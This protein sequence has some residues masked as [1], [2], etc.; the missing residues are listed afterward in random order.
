MTMRLPSLLCALVLLATGLTACAFADTEALDARACRL[1]ADCTE[2]GFACEAGYCQLRDEVC[3]T[4]VD[5]EDGSYCNGVARC[6]PGSPL[7]NEL[8]CVGG[9]PPA[10]TDGIA[11]TR[12]SCDESTQSVVHTPSAD[13][14]CETNTDHA[15]CEALAAAR[16]QT[17]DSARCNAELT[18]DFSNCL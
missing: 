6:D 5:C 16:G 9:A 11:C 15:S 8:G 7:A 17:C 2:P 18:C 13:C 1:N 3:T 4:D 14:I 10:I 12:D